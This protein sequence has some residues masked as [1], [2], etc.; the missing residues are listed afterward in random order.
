MIKTMKKLIFF[1]SFII[2]AGCT[3]AQNKAKI[4]NIP[5]YKILIADSTY[6]TQA[7]LKKNEPVMIIYFSPDCS[8]CQQLMYDMKGQMKDF[9]K[10][11]IVMI[12]DAM[13]KLVKGFYR[14]FGISQYPNIIVGTEQNSYAIINYYD[15][16]MTPYIAIYNHKGKLV[17]AYDKVPKLKELAAM[18]KKA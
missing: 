3:Q 10:I 1:L 7:N 14:D 13:Y 6:R 5:S 11:Q 4:Q 17:K 9:S 15:V 8:H 16:K 18:V 2:V 12:T